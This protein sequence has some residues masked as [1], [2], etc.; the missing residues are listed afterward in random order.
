MKK[1]YHLVHYVED[2][3]S[4]LKKFSSFKAMKKFIIDFKAK[5]KDAD[6][7][8][9]DYAVTDITGAFIPLDNSCP[10]LE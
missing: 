6:D 5:H 4:R 2:C 7:F 1:K 8:W 9:I 10:E 3:S